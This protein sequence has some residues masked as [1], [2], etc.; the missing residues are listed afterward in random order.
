M[1]IEIKNI[2]TINFMGKL[3]KFGGGGVHLA[4]LKEKWLSK[5]IL[6]NEVRG[7]EAP[8]FT[9]LNI[10]RATVRSMTINTNSLSKFGAN[11]IIISASPY[12]PDVILAHRLSRRFRKPM[13]IYVHH[14]PPGF[15]F[16]PFRRGIF[17]VALNRIYILL[18]LA[19]AVFYRVPIF[20]D[21]PNTI[22]VRD[23]TVFPDLDAV[24]TSDCGEYYLPNLNKTVDICYIGRIQKSKGVED[25][26]KVVRILV[27]EYHFTP[28]VVLAGKGEDGYLKKIR[29]MIDYYG[30]SN[31]IIL[32]GFISDRGKTELLRNSKVFIFLS[33][34][35]GWSLSVMEAASCG[36]PI[37]AYDLP[38]YY[39]LEGTYF[40][41]RPSDIR[42]CAEVIIKVISEYESSSRTGKKAQ[43]LTSKF[44]YD[45]ISNQQLIFFEKIIKDYRDSNNGF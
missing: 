45:S 37:V 39:Y 32:K 40:S 26:I 8:S 29:R 28:K 43:E 41:I 13:T 22:G 15:F 3:G 36:L 34:E 14:I 5:G 30:L 25:L 38:A 7:V 20:L 35:E 10:L 6:V 1:D 44:T 4:I 42:Q 24:S 11:D 23:L 18:L 31:D 9:L 21:N 12:P 27:R 19:F 2:A 17:R 33:Y 16:H